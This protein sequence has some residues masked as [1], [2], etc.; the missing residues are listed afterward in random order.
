MNEE[1]KKKK[2]VPVEKKNPAKGASKARSSEKEDKR[3]K[4]LLEENKKITEEKEQY[5][6]KLAR[7][8]ADF[9]NFRKR[10]QEENM[11]FRKM[12]VSE[13]LMELLPVADN[14]ELALKS[15]D[16]ETGD[17]SLENLKKGVEMVSR[18]FMEV[19]QKNGVE[20]IKAVG[21]L[22]DPAYHE[23][24][25]VIDSEEQKEDEIVSQEFQTGYMLYGNVIRPS[26]VQVSKRK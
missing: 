22:F 4:K 10:S 12:A 18:Q 8:M 17:D 11:R 23:A 16:G 24:V 26:R 2:D 5:Y 14:L 20:P 13:L 15:M 21:E 9:E 7:V 1:M 25:M 6:D 3:I 19:L